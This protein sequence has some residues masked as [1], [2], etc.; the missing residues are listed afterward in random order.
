MY[1]SIGEITIEAEEKEIEQGRMLYRAGAVRMVKQQED[2]LLLDV[3][4]NEG[5][6]LLHLSTERGLCS[7]QKHIANCYT[8]A[9]LLFLDG[10]EDF[11]RLLRALS[12]KRAQE[13]CELSLKEDIELLEVALLPIVEVGED[14]VF[15]RF[16]IGAKRMYK[17]R[18]IAAAWE[19]MQRNETLVF[20]KYFSFDKNHCRLDE[21]DKKLLESVYMALKSGFAQEHAGGVK[22]EPSHA[23]SL[24]S[25]FRDKRFECN[26]KMQRG[27][28]KSMLPFSLRV[29]GNGNA[30]RLSLVSAETFRT[31]DEEGCFCLG[32]EGIV[33]LSRQDGK[34][35]AFFSK[36]GLTS[37]PNILFSRREFPT[38]L[39][40]ILPFLERR[41]SVSFEGN[42]AQLIVKEAL[43][44]KIYI[45]KKGKNISARVLFCYGDAELDAF[46][47]KSDRLII[48]D[49]EGEKNILLVMEALGFRFDGESLILQD[50]DKIYAFLSEGLADIKKH[51]QTF[52]SRQFEKV[53]LRKSR[54]SGHVSMR[55]GSIVLDMFDDGEKIDDVLG[56][57]RSIE[58]GKKYF[59]LNDQ[60]FIVLEDME[61]FSQI[62]SLVK[63]H[64]TEDFLPAFHASQINHIVKE[65]ALNV[66]FSKEAMDCAAL[67][68]KDLECP[69]ASMHSYQKRGMQWLYALYLFGLGGILAD[70]M[71][72]GKT[73]QLLSALLEARR[74]AE[75]EGDFVGPSIV[76]VPSSL[77][78]H[79]QN[80]VQKFA[81]DI[82]CILLVG[83][84]E[85]RVKT[86]QS[87]DKR[88]A[89]LVIVSYPTLRKDI[90]VLKKIPFAFCVLDEAQSIKNPYGQTSRAA[91]MLQGRC[92]ICLS[93][94]PMENS[95]ADLWSLFDF[96][97]QGF[98]PHLNEYIR[99]YAGGAYDALHKK[100]SPFIMRRMKKD[101][102]SE[103][104]DKMESTYLAYMPKEQ[105]MIYRAHKLRLRDR[106][107]K[108]L[109]DD[110]AGKIRGEI[111][112][113][114]TELRQ[115]CCSPRLV[116][117]NYAYSGGKQL[118]LM[119][120]LPQILA[121][122]HRVLLFSQFTTMLKILKEDMEQRDIPCFY[123]DGKTRLEDRL[124]LVERFN[125]GEAKV[126]LISLKA[127]GTGLNLTG[128][129]TVI[130]F[131]PWWNPQSENQAIDR[132]HRLGQE[133]TVQVI[134]LVTKGTIEE[135]VMQLSQGKRELFD[136]LIGE[137]EHISGASI[138][139]MVRLL[140][141]E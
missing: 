105:E 65:H 45:D 12:R 77:V 100:I 122:G 110:N 92:K 93:G 28:A 94:T 10:R 70:E 106:L 136:A 86:L 40:R 91:K 99:K 24:F 120:L 116:N 124:S 20:G 53:K 41:I 123:L 68:V 130:N 25:L 76:V 104:P 75:S 138:E 73:L 6:H 129:D 139:E 79:W 71:G 60:S 56:L 111:L 134:R 18:N 88:E 47:G 49:G 7:D 81:P 61:G 108:A 66:S 67:R 89:I 117:E 34:I 97:L 82:P 126:F 83:K 132:A 39:G 114:L 9:A 101:V 26:G 87:L 102:I 69:I 30:I 5:S 72:L 125:A 17:M 15:L 4:T 44:T 78:Y 29:S 133:K 22:I 11:T 16:Q 90:D 32:D 118:L 112:S 50:P 62:A 140:K 98:L 21:K 8:I 63:E 43:S 27:I 51:A 58:E 59:R 137:G 96:C 31:L 107:E 3:Q 46:S 64:E 33:E 35:A 84:K 14:G 52:V 13:L 135:K 42:I 109:S 127:G 141:G 23:G 55:Q 38:L 54:L 85:E 95:I 57:L 19:A 36:M 128:A 37:A 103:L 119:D 131:D 2:A 1:F 74:I 80:E 48:R 121:N 115:V 113:W